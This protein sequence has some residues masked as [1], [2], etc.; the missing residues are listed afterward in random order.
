MCIYIYIYIYKHIHT[1]QARD[2]Y[3]AFERLF[4]EADEETRKGDKDVA[5]MR[6]KLKSVF[7]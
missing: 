2:H 7:A 6:A 1:Y 4:Q 5:D 3:E